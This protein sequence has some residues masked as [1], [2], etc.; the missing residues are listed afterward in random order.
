VRLAC[1]E[2]DHATLAEPTV[3]P[4]AAP[5]ASAA[6]RHVAYEG[7]LVITGVD[8]DRGVPGQVRLYVHL[9]RRREAP[10]ARGPWRPASDAATVWAAVEGAVEAS[11][12][13]PALAPGQ[14]ATVV[15]DL[16]AAGTGAR[17]RLQSPD[18]TTLARL[19]P[20]H[21]PVAG[22]LAVAFPGEAARYVPLG[23]EMVFLGYEGAADDTILRP[24]FPPYAR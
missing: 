16:P 10:I 15:V 3:Q 4:N 19:G 2:G 18:G 11:A 1:E 9:A 17:L 7:G 20:W 14:A 12:A 8:A 24:R 6:P 21:L 23:G 22:E 13:V 5:F